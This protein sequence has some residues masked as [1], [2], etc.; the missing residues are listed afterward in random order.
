MS[1]ASYVSIERG[2]CVVC[3]QP[4]SGGT[5]MIE[6][7]LQLDSCVLGWEL[8]TADARM[9]RLGFV[10]L[11]ECELDMTQAKSGDAIAPYEVTRTGK[12]MHVTRQMFV[13]IFKGGA[14]PGLPCAYVPQGVLQQLRGVMRRALN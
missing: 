7:H 10:A 11:V 4:F 1:K 5:L 8:C 12:V 13:T 14:R 9:H 3:G 6:K 2:V